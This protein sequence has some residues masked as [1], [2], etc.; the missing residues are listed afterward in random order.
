MRAAIATAAGYTAPQREGV[1]YST[2]RA[3]D[4]RGVALSHRRCD[5]S[6]AW[7]PHFGRRSRDSDDG[8][9]GL[10][11]RRALRRL[12]MSADVVPYDAVGQRE[13]H[14]LGARLE[15]QLAHDVG[16]VR[17]DGADRDEELLAD[18]LV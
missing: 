18:L 8:V 11:P 13:H 5:R 3:D 2:M 4:R 1:P 16:A 6:A 9:P 14:E 17:V 7:F 12:N 15:L 10:P